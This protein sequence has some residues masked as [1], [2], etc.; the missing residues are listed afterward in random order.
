MEMKTNEGVL[1]INNARNTFGG[2][3]VTTAWH[4]PGLWK[5]ETASSYGR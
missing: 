1:I 3:L 5:E 4:V 2:S